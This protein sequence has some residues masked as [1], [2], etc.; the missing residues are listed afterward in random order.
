MTLCKV[1]IKPSEITPLI[2]LRT[3]EIIKE[4]DIPAGVVVVTGYGKIVGGA[5]TFTGSILTGNDAR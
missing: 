4:G 2:A 3:S 5:M 1:A